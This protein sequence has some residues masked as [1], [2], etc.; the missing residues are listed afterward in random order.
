MTRIPR[1][2]GA[3]NGSRT[4]TKV[5][6]EIPTVRAKD[7]VTA[8]TVIYASWARVLSSLT[9]ATDIVFG[10]LVSGR[11]SAHASFHQVVGLCINYVPVRTKLDETEPRRV[12]ASLQEQYIRGL[13]HEA[14][15]LTEI[16][17]QCTDW[18]ADSV[19]GSTVH[20]QNVEEEPPLSLDGRNYVRLEAVQDSGCVRVAA[21]PSGSQCKLDLSMPPK[22]ELREAQKLL[23]SLADA[24]DLFR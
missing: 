9:G 23:N 6:T 16:V 10:R 19:F 15:G 12:L 3:R 5:C 17:D 20:Y 24:I 22:L 4:R 8:A 2:P 14:L 7:N 1:D 11:N 21:I 18:P 13:Q